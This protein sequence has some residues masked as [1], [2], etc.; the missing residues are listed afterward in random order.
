[1]HIHGE[2]LSLEE[3]LKKYER[4][5]VY[6]VY[7]VNPATRRQLMLN[8][9]HKETE[10]II[11]R[12]GLKYIEIPD[13]VNIGVTTYAIIPGVKRLPPI[14]HIKMMRPLYNLI[15]VDGNVYKEDMPQEYFLHYRMIIYKGLK[16]FYD[17]A[18]YVMIISLV[19]DNKS[20]ID[21]ILN[22]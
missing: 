3:A 11:V 15:P 2:N 13:D 20:L 10:E 6:A 4:Q 21:E 1:M 22:L 5:T 9:G 19:T 14:D 17:A 16:V 12:D 18:G 7:Y 8:F